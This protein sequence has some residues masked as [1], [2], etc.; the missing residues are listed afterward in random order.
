MPND[1][2][3]RLEGRSSLGRV[4]LLVNLNSRYV[5]PGF[6]GKVT[7]ELFNITNRPIRL[8]PGMRIA[9]LSI[10]RIDAPAIHPYGSPS[11]GSHY[12]RQSGATPPIFSM[13]ANLDKE[14][15]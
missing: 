10:E 6:E 8:L 12:Q 14:G 9:Q 15:E 7:L 1:M 2:L 5:D 4:G 13:L 3:G 11:L